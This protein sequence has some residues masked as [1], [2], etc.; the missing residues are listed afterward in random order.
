[1]SWVFCFQ[2]DPWLTTEEL[3]VNA[4]KTKSNAPGHSAKRARTERMKAFRQT[5]I[6][7]PSKPI[8]SEET[9]GCAFSDWRWV[10]CWLRR[11]QW[12]RLLLRWERTAEPPRRGR[13]P[14]SSKW[15]MA[16]VR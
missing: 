8:V 12:R 15:P 14:V 4:D 7:T 16:A 9:Q 3:F 13:H 6:A 10:E 5:V 11:P 2:E 1:M